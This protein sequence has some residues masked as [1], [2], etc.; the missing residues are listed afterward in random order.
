MLRLFE[1]SI[2]LK[3]SGQLA[4]SVQ[5][6]VME[7][8][9]I[10]L[11]MIC[12]LFL[13]TAMVKSAPLSLQAE[14]VYNHSHQFKRIVQYVGEPMSHEES[15]AS[16]AVRQ[17]LAVCYHTVVNFSSIGFLLICFDAIKVRAAIKVKAA[18]IV[19]FTSSGRAS[20]YFNLFF[21]D[22]QV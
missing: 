5:K 9:F 13:R 8:D 16:S 12:S 11:T 10:A 20:R 22:S 18:V 14:S 7:T 6:Y 3:Q 2:L 15:V 21:Q 19:V 1:A 4:K 17:P